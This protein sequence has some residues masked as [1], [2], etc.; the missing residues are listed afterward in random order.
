MTVSSLGL[1]SRQSIDTAGYISYNSYKDLTLCYMKK[2]GPHHCFNASQCALRTSARRLA[3]AVI[4]RARSLVRPCALF[5]RA[6]LDCGPDGG[7]R[8]FGVGV[9]VVD[10]VYW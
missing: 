8:R 3:F 1:R 2:G 9:A 10:G 4:S 7:T 6:R 5:F